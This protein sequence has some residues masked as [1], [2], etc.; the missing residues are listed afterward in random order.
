MNL[1]LCLSHSHI[2]E[3][4]HKKRQKSTHKQPPLT[5]VVGIECQLLYIGVKPLNSLR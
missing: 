1:H 5:D 2:N 4:T 3:R